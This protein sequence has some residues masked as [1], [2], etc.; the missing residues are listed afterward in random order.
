M[1]KISVD[2]AIQR[3]HLMV[4]YPAIII[5]FATLLMSL[6]LFQFVLLMPKWAIYTTLIPA[7]AATWLWWSY[8]IVKWR[9]WAFEHCRNVHEL[10]RRAISEYLIWQEGS[11]FEKTEIRSEEQKKKLAQ[12]ALKFEIPDE[13]E[14]IKDDGSVPVETKI[15]P[16]KLPFIIFGMG[17]VLEF[18][19]GI[20]FIRRGEWIGDI[21]IL[22]SFGNFYL[23]SKTSNILI[24][25][26]ILN[27]KGIKTLNTSFTEWDKVYAI[28]IVSAPDVNKPHLHLVLE[29][30]EADTAGNWG[31]LINVSGLNKSPGKIEQLIKLYQQRHR[32][33]LLQFPSN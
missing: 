28:E 3:G 1:E 7:F 6:Y 33:V 20:F 16:S 2:K 13:L 9:I 31:D 17:G 15:Y 5:L 8:M 11:R 29:F 14:W 19:A 21:G 10:K 24:P 32:N 27:A 22:I 25:Y 4:S 30:K 12:L 18:L 26:I 23:A